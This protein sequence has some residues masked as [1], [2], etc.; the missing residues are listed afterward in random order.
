MSEDDLDMTAEDLR[1]ELKFLTQKYSILERNYNILMEERA[2]QEETG[3][4][5]DF[6]HEEITSK[7]AGINFHRLCSFIASSYFL[8]NT[9][10]IA[11]S[12]KTISQLRNKLKLVVQSLA[13]QRKALGDIKLEFRQATND[14]QVSILLNCCN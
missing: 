6:Y 2:I 12:N 1:Y 5:G 3:E 7:N 9:T 10:E 8:L 11:Q 13:L 4:A 14:A